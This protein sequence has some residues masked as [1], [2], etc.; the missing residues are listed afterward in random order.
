MFYV[1]WYPPIKYIVTGGKQKSVHRAR[2]GSSQ[3]N[4]V[5]KDNKHIH[6]LFHTIYFVEH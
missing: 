1:D 6:K 5:K 4:K 2:I 3:N